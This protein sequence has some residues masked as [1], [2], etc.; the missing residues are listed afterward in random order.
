[1]QAG[2]HALSFS[3][4]ASLVPH[5]VENKII[6][7]RSSVLNMEV[8]KCNSLRTNVATLFPKNLVCKE[9]SYNFITVK[10][11][12]KSVTTSTTAVRGNT[13]IDTRRHIHTQDKLAKQQ[14]SF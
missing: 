10:I 9:L 13:L 12:V 3:V 7:V 14:R 6:S 8:K 2:F 1:M 5:V 11:I 4:I